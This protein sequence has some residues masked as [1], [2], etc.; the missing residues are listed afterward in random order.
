M[1]VKLR[2]IFIVKHLIDSLRCLEKLEMQGKGQNGLDKMCGAVCRHIGILHCII[3]NVL[4]PKK[5]NRASEKGGSLHTGSSITTHEH[6][7]R[8]VYKIYLSIYL[9]YLSLKVL[10]M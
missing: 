10:Y 3:T 6:A 7:L 5:K 2:E 1:K 8:L 4:Q 9:I